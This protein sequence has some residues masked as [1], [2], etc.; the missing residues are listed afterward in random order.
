MLQTLN[1]RLLFTHLLVAIVAI[2]LVGVLSSQLFRSYY[3]NQVRSD[4]RLAAEDLSSSL[5]RV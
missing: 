1:S 2:G 4:L 3:V 5:G